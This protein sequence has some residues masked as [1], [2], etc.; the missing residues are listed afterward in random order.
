MNDDR[1][2]KAQRLFQDTVIDKTSLVGVEHF[3]AYAFVP[4]GIEHDATQRIGTRIFNVFNTDKEPFSLGI[5]V[6]YEPTHL[7]RSWYEIPKEF[8]VESDKRTFSIGNMFS[9]ESLIEHIEQTRRG[10]EQTRRFYETVAGK[11]AIHFFEFLT[12]QIRD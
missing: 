3:R 8:Q 10:A 5:I 2:V 12:V 6:P 1:S 4:D 9:V 11:T 7:N